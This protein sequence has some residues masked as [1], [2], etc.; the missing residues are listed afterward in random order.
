MIMIMTT[1]EKIVRQSINQVEKRLKEINFILESNPWGEIFKIRQE[2][3][4]LLDENQTIEQMTSPE[5]ISKIK[6]LAKREKAQ[7][8][9]VERHKDILKLIDEKV[10]LEFELQ[11]LQRELYFIE[12]KNVS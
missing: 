9:L 3:Q 4:R 11:D 1:K 5:F 8:K 10:K 6:D 12:R 2:G 7:F